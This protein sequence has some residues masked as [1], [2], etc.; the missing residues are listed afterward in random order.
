MS[1]RPIYR[2]LLLPDFLSVL[3]RA[4]TLTLSPGISGCV[5]A[6][7]R[8]RRGF[9]PSLNRVGNHAMLSLKLKAASMALSACRVS[10][11]GGGEGSAG[12]WLGFWAHSM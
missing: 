8:Q 10:C 1:R 5:P 6:L 12:C 9:V 4:G 3:P 11:G 7:K 2:A